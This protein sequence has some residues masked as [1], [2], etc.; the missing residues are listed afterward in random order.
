[1]ADPRRIAAA[2][3]ATGFAGDAIRKAF[4]RR[5]GFPDAK[6]TIDS[7]SQ[8]RRYSRTARW[9]AC[10]FEK[11]RNAP[12]Y[13]GIAAKYRGKADAQQLL[14]DH[15]TSNPIVESDDGQGFHQAAKTDSPEKLMNLIDWILS[16][17]Q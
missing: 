4:W 13:K 3:P 2:L 11:R 5:R 16:R 7:G 6:S 10:P 9:N 15:L 12:S 17:G 1:M 8:S 14:V